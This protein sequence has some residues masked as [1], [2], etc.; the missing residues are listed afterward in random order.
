MNVDAHSPKVVGGEKG[1]SIL[2]SHFISHSQVY[3]I[4]FFSRYP[5]HL[6]IDL[7]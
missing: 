3:I 7:C 6:V 2:W 1:K 4:D 5:L